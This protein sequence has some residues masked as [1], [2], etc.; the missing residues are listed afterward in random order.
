M[1]G[2]DVS[3]GTPGP[4]LVNVPSIDPTQAQAGRVLPVSGGTDPSILFEDMTAYPVPVNGSCNA[5]RF[6]QLSPQ[7]LTFLQTAFP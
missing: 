3:S 6:K 5:A 2:V 4:V 1:T 7:M